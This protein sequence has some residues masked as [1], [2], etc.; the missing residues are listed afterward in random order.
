MYSC[1][2]LGIEVFTALDPLLYSKGEMKANNSH[3]MKQVQWDSERLSIPG[4]YLIEIQTRELCTVIQQSDKHGK[5]TSKI[6]ISVSSSL[7]ELAKNESQL[8]KEPFSL[9]IYESLGGKEANVYFLN[10]MQ[11]EYVS[12]HVN[13]RAPF[14]CRACSKIIFY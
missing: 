1:M 10:E 11:A 13:S 14:L 7:I 6:F 2:N 5:N 3:A 12:G 4:K 9:E 8:K